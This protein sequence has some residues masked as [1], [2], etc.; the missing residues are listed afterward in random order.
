ML[1]RRRGLLPLACLMLLAACSKTPA[2]DP[3]GQP[4]AA[5]PAEAT[6]PEAG[7]GEAATPVSV[8]FADKELDKLEAEAV[9]LAVDP[10]DREGLVRGALEALL[11]GPTEA[12]HARVIP[13]A[14]ALNGVTIDGDTAVVDLTRS[15]VDG[16]QG[17]SN[18]AALAVYSVVNTA[19]AVPGVSKVLLTFEGQPGSEFGGALDLS[20]PLTADPS[21]VGSK[22]L[23]S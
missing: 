12:A 9:D 8:Y 7:A 22:R 6:T 18:A 4:P 5:T 11:A 15:F 2:P 17:G 14:A 3:A 16:F 13:E 20:K 21:L 1:H 10:S 19:T 23:G